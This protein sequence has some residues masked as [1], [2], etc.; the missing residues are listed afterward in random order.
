VNTETMVSADVPKGQPKG[1]W[2][3]IFTEAWERFSHYGMRAILILY[4]TTSVS[5]GGM[6]LDKM[7]ASAIFGGYMLSIYLF[8]LSGGQIAD[9]FLGAKRT[10]LLGGLF[11]AAGQILLQVHSLNGLVASLVLIAIGTCLLK[12]NISASVGKLYAKNDSRRDGAYTYEYMGINIG[13][14]V[15]PIVCGLMAENPSF[16]DFLNRIGLNTTSGWAW[17]FGISGVGMLIGLVN[18]VLRR[19]LVVDVSIPEGQTEPAPKSFGFVAILIA[20]LLAMAWMVIASPNWKIQLLLGAIA[21]AGAMALVQ[22]L[23]N[24]GMIETRVPVAVSAN[25][26]EEHQQFTKDDWN[27]VFVVLMML[28]FS[29]TFWFVFQQAGSTLTLFGKEYTNRFIGSFEVPASWA[30]SV[31]AILIVALGP[32]FAWIWTKRGGKFPSSPIK[33][34]MGLLL[35]ALG[36][37][38]IVP[39][40]K[41]ARPLLTSPISKVGM[42]WL[43]GVLLLHTL[44]ELCI[45]PVGMSYVSKLAPKQLGSQLM[46]AWFFAMG[47]GSYMAGKAAGLMDSYPVWQIFAICAIIALGMSLL[48]WIIISRVIHKLMGGYS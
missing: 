41:F 26:T 18:F 32:L 13:A 14:M 44:G 9:R 17:A 8:G 19:K 30:P 21:S 15:A 45:S 4:L 10:I 35:V 46:G 31:N 23:I 1:L 3:L 2:V 42:G 33:F 27:R 40:A 37:F 24:K 11:I 47:I 7:R 38:L 48:L 12:P 25:A 43:G 5:M 36:F 6:G 16:V 28:A 39:A 29:A 34:A 22:V 20:V